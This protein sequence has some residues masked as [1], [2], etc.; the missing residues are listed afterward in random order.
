MKQLICISC[1]KGCHLTVDEENDYAVTGNSCPRGEIYG[2]TEIKNPQ[3]IVTSTV[4]VSGSVSVRCPVK[5]NKTIPK[6]LMFEAMKTLDGISIPAPIHR[7][8]II[9]ADVCKTGADFIATKG[10]E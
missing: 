1:P 4:A 2:K 8:Q 5:T 6:R 7:G 3:R 10:I 9:V